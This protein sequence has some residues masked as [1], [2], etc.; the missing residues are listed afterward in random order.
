M[1]F[2]KQNTITIISILLL[3]TSIISCSDDSISNTRHPVPERRINQSI[4]LDY[5]SELN[6]VG[7][8][9]YFARIN[10][11]NVGY[12]DHGIIVTRTE[13]KKFIAFDA[14]CPHDI[15]AD[16]HVEI[17]GSF[18]V[19]PKCKSKFNLFTRYPFKGSV[20]KYPLRELYTTYRSS[21]NQ[22][23]IYN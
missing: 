14:T 3:A 13:P 4:N 17:K 9:K 21:E 18:A 19:C 22:L 11:S 7:N 6:A 5:H 8:S 16:T 10:G 12:L 15:M 23:R 1:V 20:A 2:S